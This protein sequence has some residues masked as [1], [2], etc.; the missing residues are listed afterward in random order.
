[1]LP[2]LKDYGYTMG[3]K[4]TET[5]YFGFGS[6]FK[7]RWIPAI[8]KELDDS[9]K[10]TKKEI[11]KITKRLEKI[12]DLAV[13]SP[14]S[15][16]KLPTR[17]INALDIF[18]TT[19]VLAH[20]PFATV[21]SIS[22]P[23]IALA[24]SDLLS[25]TPSFVKEY[26]KAGILQIRK[27]F[28][29]NGRLWD[30]ISL[31]SGKKVYGFKDLTDEAFLD[32]KR[33]GVAV[34]QSM[35]A[36]VEGM[37]AENIQNKS[38]RNLNN[39]FF[40]VTL[41]QQWTQAVQ[42]GSFNFA[43]ARTIRITKE[44]T[45][46]KNQFGKQLSKNEIKRRKNQLHEIGIDSQDAMFAYRN[47]IIN[48]E[49]DL[50]TFQDKPFYDTQLNP[51]AQVFAKEVILNPSASNMNK[52][53]WFSNPFAQVAV[54][55]AGYPT[56]FNNTVL[57]G[58]ARDLYRYPVQSAPAIIAA[59]TMMTGVAHL[60]NTIRSRG[61]NLKKDDQTLL[62]DAV[63]RPGLMG[64]ASHIYRYHRGTAFNQGFVGGIT[65]AFG[66]PIFSD[67]ADA[68]QYSSTPY[69]LAVQ[70]MPFYGGLS[71]KSRREL[72]KWAQVKHHQ[73]Y[74]K[75]KKNLRSIKSKGGVVEDVLNVISEPDER[76]IRGL[77]NTYSGMAGVLFQ[78]EEERGA[79]ATGG[80]VSIKDTDQMYGYLTKDE[81]EY[82]VVIDKDPIRVY[83][84]EDFPDLHIKETYYT[85]FKGNTVSDRLNSVRHSS[86]IGLP[87]TT[88]KKKARGVVQAAGKI[89]FNNVLKLN[90]DTATPDAVQ[91]ELNKNM[92][93]LIKIEDKILGKEIIKAAN[94]N[95]AIRDDVFNNDPDQTLEKETV[96]AKSKS[97][98][99]RHQLLKLGY[100]AI[101]TKEG[102]TLLR[103]NQF[104]PT[105]IIDKR[106]PVFI[107]GLV[108]KG[109]GLLG[110]LLRR[111]KRAVNRAETKIEDIQYQTKD[112]VLIGGPYQAVPR[113]VVTDKKILPKLFRDKLRDSES[114]GRY[115]VVNS[116][117]YMGAYQFGNSRLKDYRDRYN[118]SFTNEEFLTDNKLQDEVFDWH[119]NDIRKGIKRNKLDQYIGQK[120]NGVPIT[121]PGMV[122]VAHLGGFTGMQRFITN[123]GKEDK[124]DDYG[125]KMSDY[126]DKFKHTRFEKESYNEGG[127]ATVLHKRQ[128]Y[129]EGG[130]AL[131]FNQKYHLE[132]IK[133]KR[134]MRNS[135]GQTVTAA[136]N[137]FEQ[138]GMVYN[139]PTY[140]RRGSTI[141]K[142]LEFFKEDIKAGRIQGYKADKETY[143]EDKNNMH[144]HPAN[145]A[146]NKEHKMMEDKTPED[147]ITF[148]AIKMA[149][150]KSTRPTIEEVAAENKRRDNLN[151][152]YGLAPARGADVSLLSSVLETLKKR[153]IKNNRVNNKSVNVFDD[154]LKTLPVS[155]GKNHNVDNVAEPIMKGFNSVE[156][157]NQAYIDEVLSKTP[158]LDSE[159]NVSPDWKNSYER[160]NPY[161]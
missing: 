110:A 145:V 30:Q 73:H 64:A 49:F 92:D 106:Q 25:D 52:P 72:R 135:K 8:T 37:F 124:Q 136:V 101:E 81:D 118:K 71:P 128:Q 4:I 111:S 133:Q 96:I 53:V 143:S 160:D 119:V 14:N 138:D 68:I 99:V 115:D 108:E 144:L 33:W 142:P 27:N 109:R 154:P 89:K 6:N 58:F 120:I 18:R 83:T 12:K 93:S 35:M 91:A 86:T 157:S 65:K 159:G 26:G 3:Q 150:I 129:N 48:G 19:Q 80:K 38:A 112:A 137:G 126:L 11:I 50:K 127:L 63:E 114:S 7:E 1:M 28:G 15:H 122:G 56:A 87:V 29:T 98:L 103:E 77:P 141:R 100:D 34:E 84:K 10:F 155:F 104:L 139:L 17:A 57:K 158:Y 74:G 149:S 146:A 75:P 69:D 130:K 2:L 36:R 125:T 95:L 13:G 40:N 67:Y 16:I 70:N 131:T 32:V 151:I 76:K 5:K 41:L 23:F 117:G 24:K 31:T 66:G 85:G 152:E 9:G 82:N 123:L 134:A 44:L 45:E 113:S 62:L 47:S 43:K 39:M 140:D 148:G 51:G 147:A 102:Y 94:D 55:F 156:E 161:D 61:E 20:L 46:G 105:D 60:G 132:T 79:F 90:I 97:F 78:D 88:N 121:E 59:T 116:L 22:E 107:G 153:N 21:S 42:M 54:Q